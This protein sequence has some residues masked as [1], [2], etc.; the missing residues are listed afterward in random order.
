ML[1]CDGSSVLLNRACVAKWRWVSLR[2]SRA[3]IPLFTLTAAAALAEPGAAVT[4]RFALVGRHWFVA[5]REV[6]DL[7][8]A[9]VAAG[10]GFGSRLTELGACVAAETGRR[11]LVSCGPHGVVFCVRDRTAPLDTLLRR[12]HFRG[13]T[14]SDTFIK[15]IYHH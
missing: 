5:A 15:L 3:L 8:G 12:M 4:A 11:V 14:Y 2:A 9:L 7:R 6:A 13:R 10:A 1:R